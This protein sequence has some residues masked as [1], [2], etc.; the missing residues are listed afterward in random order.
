M[1]RQDL[2]VRPASPTNKEEKREV[3][4]DGSRVDGPANEWWVA[5]ASLTLILRIS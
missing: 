2:A 1:A 5:D 3:L 4:G